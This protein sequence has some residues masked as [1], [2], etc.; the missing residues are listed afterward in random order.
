MSMGNLHVKTALL[1][2]MML[3]LERLFDEEFIHMDVERD[4]EH[5]AM[6]LI[7]SHEY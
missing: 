1:V 3:L 6:E 2:E 4:F 7:H 5:L